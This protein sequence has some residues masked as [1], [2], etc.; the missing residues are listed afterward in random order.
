VEKRNC[1]LYHNHA[2]NLATANSK[3]RRKMS[4][5]QRNGHW[6]LSVTV[7]GKIIRKAIKEA[8]TR[9]QAEKAERILRDEIYEN[10]FGDGGQRNFADFVEKSYKPYA[11]EHKRGYR[12]ELSILN[13]LI[14]EFGK[15]R[16]NEVT[17][18]AVE[19]FKRQRASEI[20]NRGNLRSKST[21]NRDVAVLAAVFNLA[22][23][24]G[25]VKNNPVSS[26]KYYTNLNSRERVL[27]DD[28]EIVLFELIG[29]DV[30]FSRKVEILLY[31]GMRRGELF[32]LEWRDIDLTESVI[33]IRKETTKTGK[34]RTIPMMSN[35]RKIFEALRDEAG[36]ASD[37]D[38]IFIG[39]AS[40]S[41]SFSVKFNKI[42]AGLG[43]K[44]L[45][46]HSLRHTFSTRCDRYK[47]GAF[48]QKALLGHAKLSMTDKYTH[49]SIETLKA[50]LEGMEQHFSR[51][52]NTNTKNENQNDVER[53]NLL[54]FKKK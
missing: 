7:N 51:A 24:F 9:R 19:K 35:V 25:E 53:P 11:K 12:V 3:V 28:E 27:S 44:D 10:R 33:N 13:V 36:D 40:Q 21:V 29:E 39:Y 8:R 47:V 6:H 31:T 34:P 38:K 50:S 26:V 41:D 2:Q 14:G 52:K 54:D 20:T 46:V 37:A 5:F 1:V 43:F 18:E 23:D 16:L 30:N 48:A 4:V 15:R 42:C 22:K 49:L 45:T 32:K 17:P